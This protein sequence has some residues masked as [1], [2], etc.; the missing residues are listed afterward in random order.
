M[1]MRKFL[2]KRVDAQRGDLNAVF[3]D[4]ATPEAAVAMAPSPGAWKLHREVTKDEVR[5]SRAGVILAPCF[6]APSAR[7]GRRF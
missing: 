2:L 1:T 7:G 6:H 5:A 4:A 3:V